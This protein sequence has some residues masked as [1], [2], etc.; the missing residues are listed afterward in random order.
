MLARRRV[1]SSALGAL[2]LVASC[3]G[4]GSHAFG[5]HS[6]RPMVGSTVAAQPPFTPLPRRQ[7]SPLVLIGDSMAN[8]SIRELRAAAARSG[9]PLQLHTQGKA[10]P[11]N[12]LGLVE[13]AL[14]AHPRVVAIEWIGNTSFTSPCTRAFFPAEVAAETRRA[15]ERIAAVRRPGTTVVLVGIPPIVQVPWD[16]SRTALEPLY[17]S[18]VATHPGFAYADTTTALAPDGRFHATLPCRPA[19]VAAKACGAFGAPAGQVVV[20]DSIGLHFCP[21]RY[22]LDVE[23][24]PVI[25]SGAERYAEAIVTRLRAVAL[26]R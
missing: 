1:A 19:D 25:S 26:A 12:Q 11:C 10:G 15:L 8:E 16:G 17:R 14:A 5:M 20:R 3:G 23:Q 2:A 24:C 13:Q 7:T 4:G 18:W 21:V 9:L 6:T 22:V